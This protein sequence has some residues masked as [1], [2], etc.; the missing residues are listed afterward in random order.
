[1][2]K[3]YSIKLNANLKV[4]K[5]EIAKIGTIFEG[6]QEELPTWLQSL[7]ALKTHQSRL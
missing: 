1:M 7:I 2:Q 5:D 6:T 3:R 4:G